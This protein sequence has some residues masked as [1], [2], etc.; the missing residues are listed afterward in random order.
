MKQV[1]HLY[2]QSLLDPHRFDFAS[3]KWLYEIKSKLNDYKST[4][5]ILPVFTGDD[6]KRKVPVK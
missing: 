2:L 4:E 6:I 5:G 3:D 1:N